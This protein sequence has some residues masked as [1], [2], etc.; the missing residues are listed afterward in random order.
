MISDRKFSLL[1]PRGKEVNYKSLEPSTFHDLGLD[2][3][4][5]EITSEPKEQVV[6]ADV[7]SQLTS[8]PEVTD[9]RQDI[10]EDLKDLP[11]ISKRLHR[12]FSFMNL[13]Q[14]LNLYEHLFPH[15]SNGGK[16]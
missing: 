6:I 1:F 16:P 12:S 5:K 3:I 9:Y 8:D 14:P 4:C 10:F 13:G 15:I 2:T 7:L 11:D